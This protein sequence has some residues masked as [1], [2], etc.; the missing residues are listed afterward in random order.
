MIE[1]KLYYVIYEDEYGNEETTEVLA[2]NE[3]LVRVLMGDATIIDVI[4]IED[5][6]GFE[7]RLMGLNEEEEEWDWTP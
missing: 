1:Q 7:E 5:T 2:P 3:E 6:D 4:E